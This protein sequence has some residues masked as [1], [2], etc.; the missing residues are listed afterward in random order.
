M[1]IGPL[2][3]SAPKF[4]VCT[5]TSCT[6]SMLIFAVAAPILP[7]SMIC[8]PSVTTLTWPELGANGSA[9]SSGQVNVVTDGVQIIDPGNMGAAT[10]NINMDQVQEVKVQTSNFGA[11]EAK[12]PIVINAVGKSGGSDYH[13]GL[14][15]YAR[16]HIFN[17]NDWQSNYVGVAIAPSKYYY[18]GG[19]I[20][21]PIRIPGTN[22]NKSK[23]LTFWLGF[24]YYDQLNNTNGTYGGPIYAFIPTKSMQAGDLSPASLAAAFNVPTAGLL[25]GCPADYSQSAAYSNIGGDCFSPAN[26]TLDQNGQPVNGGHLNSIDPAMATFTKL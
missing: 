10:A 7:G 3:S 26:G 25:A 9:P 11:D 6:W 16:D 12:G 15:M 20:G 24:E 1:T 14:Y 22:F 2:A 19:T 5:F 4:E 17:S 13:G 18:P 8:T 21:G 23:K